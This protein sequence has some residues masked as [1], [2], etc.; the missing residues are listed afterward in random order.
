MHD[1]AAV[2]ARTRLRIGVFEADIGGLAASSTASTP[3][4]SGALS[5]RRRAGWRLLLC[6]YSHRYRCG[7]GHRRD[8]RQELGL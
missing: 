3:A 2:G 5:A 7:E 6:G 4:G 8:A 1:A